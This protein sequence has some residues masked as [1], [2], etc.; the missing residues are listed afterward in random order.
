MAQDRL[1]RFIG[2]LVGTAVGDSLGAQREGASGFAE[3]WEIGPRYTDDTVMTL[4]VAESLVEAKGFHY[5]HMAEK[6]VKN[7]EREPWRRYGSTSPRIF[8]MMRSGRL[9]FGMLIVL[10]PAARPCKYVEQK[11]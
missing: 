11:D 6:F 1:E 5:F 2:C 4:G 10:L 8:R 9:G 3:V 7:Y